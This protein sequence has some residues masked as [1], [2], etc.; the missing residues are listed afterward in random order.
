MFTLEDTAW[1]RSRIFFKDFINFVSLRKAVI[2]EIIHQFE[3][4]Y[5]VA[6]LQYMLYLSA[7][8]Y[9]APMFALGDTAWTRG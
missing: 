6:H 4:K 5:D 3:S 9:N 1:I 8:N 2:F 7:I